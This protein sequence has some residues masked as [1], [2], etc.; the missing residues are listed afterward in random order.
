MHVWTC[1][2]I[3]PILIKTV[4][5]EF[6]GVPYSIRLIDIDT[7]YPKIV[8]IDRLS[9]CKIPERLFIVDNGFCG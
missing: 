1:C 3:V 2:V 7:F 4:I 5:V 6:D 8:F 9:S